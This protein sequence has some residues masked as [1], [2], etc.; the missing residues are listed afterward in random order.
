MQHKRLVYPGPH[1]PAATSLAARGEQADKVGP[2]GLLGA[3]TEGASIS[4]EY[5][6]SSICGA[7]HDSIYH[8]FIL[9]GHPELLTDLAEDLKPGRF[10]MSTP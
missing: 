5:V 7:C 10:S 1:I 4:T 3:A 6:G 9:S 8:K 2:E